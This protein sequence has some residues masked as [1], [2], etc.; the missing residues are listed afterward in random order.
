MRCG[1]VIGSNEKPVFSISN[2]EKK[3]LE[4]IRR[5]V[6]IN[7]PEGRFI[8]IDGEKIHCTGKRIHVQSSKKI[9]NFR[10]M[11]R[12]RRDP[13]SKQYLLVGLVGK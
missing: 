11:K 5:D 7:P 3:V 10:L 2:L 13:L 1:F 12:L 9:E 8:E 4:I 6:V